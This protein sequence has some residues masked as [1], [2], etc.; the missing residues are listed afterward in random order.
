MYA[1]SLMNKILA[2]SLLLLRTLMR[3]VDAGCKDIFTFNILN[4]YLN[5]NA[6]LLKLNL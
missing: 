5:E 2:I 4:K 6:D 1:I 3:S